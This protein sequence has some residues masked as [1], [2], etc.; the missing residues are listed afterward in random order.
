MSNDTSQ[1]RK[2]SDD[3]IVFHNK[4]EIPYI[5]VPHLHSQYEIYYNVCGARG[6][7]VSGKFYKCN[8]RE[9]I[10]VPKLQTHKVVVDKNTYYERC[11]IN[12]NEAILE[13]LASL[14]RAEDSVSWL[15]NKDGMVNLSLPQHEYFINL[16]SSYN[17]ESKDE[18]M[19]MSVFL[20]ILSF[21]KD[22]FSTQETPEFLEDEHVSYSDKVIRI[23][24]KNPGI[25]TVSEIARLL[26]INEDYINRVFREET[27]ITIKKYLIMRML[28][29]AKKHLYL[30]KTVKEACVLSG[31][32]DYSNFLRTFKKYEG[33]PPSE[34][35]DL[36][37]PL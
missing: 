26:Y 32:G 28:S 30:G 14:C 19:K 21:L 11:V 24:E 31:F 34:L 33:Y 17:D 15:R 9:L 29:E 18:F 1:F 36:T 12:I 35:E 10:I 27:G 22:A 20:N 4:N 13:Q 3:L 5:S 6:F 16:V 2:I 8:N 25:G 37:K 23:I 7:M